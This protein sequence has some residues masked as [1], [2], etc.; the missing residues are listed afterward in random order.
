MH[1]YD[2]Q[3]VQVASDVDKEIF[4]KNMYFTSV[5]NRLFDAPNVNQ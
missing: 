3:L 4:F 2:Y 5:L 1:H